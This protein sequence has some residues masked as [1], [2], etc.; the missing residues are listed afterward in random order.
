MRAALNYAL[1]PLVALALETCFSSHSAHADKAPPSSAP[2]TTEC[3]PGTPLRVS[4]TSEFQRVKGE[5]PTVLCVFRH[6]QNGFPTLNIVEEPRVEGS[7]PPTLEEYREGIARGY[8]TV[9]LSDAT[10]SSSIIGESKGG[11]FFSSEITFTNQGTPMI[12]KILVIHHHDRT[13]TASAIA[14]ATPPE[15]GRALIAPL[16]DG[17]EVDGDLVQDTK[18]QMTVWATI[19]A[20]CACLPLAYI[21]FRRARA[22]RAAP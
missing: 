21:G 8:Q 11:P 12:A 19:G 13:Y 22:R 14:E 10:L 7:K 15:A 9:G 20:I 4:I 5:L 2:W 18:S 6:K 16:I 1:A 17:I 3:A